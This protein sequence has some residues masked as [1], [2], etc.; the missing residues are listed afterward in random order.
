MLHENYL[1]RIGKSISTNCRNHHLLQNFEIL[2]SVEPSADLGQFANSM[3]VYPHPNVTG[4]MATSDHFINIL[5]VISCIITPP[6]MQTTMHVR[7]EGLFITENYS[8][9]EV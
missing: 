7:S 6:A 4:D 3:Q 1:L 8:A 2:L 9:P 5:V